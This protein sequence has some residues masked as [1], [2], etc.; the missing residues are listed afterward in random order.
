MA[1]VKNFGLIGV[2]TT[3]Q[4]GKGGPTLSANAAGGVLIADGIAGF[5]IPVG[6][7]LARPAG[8]DGIIRINSDLAAGSYTL[9]YFNGTAWSTVATGGSTGTIQ[10]EIDNIEASLGAGIDSTG[11]FLPGG[12]VAPIVGATSFTDAINQVALLADSADSLDE[13]FAPLATGNII[14]AVSDGDIGFD[15]AQGA[16][17]LTSGVQPY[18]QALTDFTANVTPGILVQTGPGAYASRTLVAPAEGITIT[19]EDGVA[20][21]PTLALANDLAGL[22]ALA[23]TG[24]SIRTGDGTWKTGTI[25]GT[26]GNIVVSNGDGVTTDTTI[27]LAPIVQASSGT[28]LKVEIGTFGRVIGNSAVVAADLTG[29]LDSTYVNVA[30]DTMADGANLTFVGGGTVTG[31]PDPVAPGD[32]SNKNY[33]DAR[34][35]GLTWK[36]PVAAATTIALPAATYDNG[37]TGVGATLTAV[38][39]LVVFPAID[40]IVSVVG[41]RILVKNQVVTTDNGIYTITALGDGAT[42]PW[43]LTRATDLDTAAEA[44]NATVFVTA[45]TTQ[46]GTGWTQITDIAVV[47]VEG[48]VFVQFTGSGTYAAGNGLTLTGNSFNVNMGA[49]IT[50]LPA[51]EVGIDLVSGLALQLT[52]ATTAGQLTFLLDGGNGVSGLEQSAT[53][54]K[55]PA[56]GVT[57]AM[58]ANPAIALNADNNAGTVAL[59]GEIE[60][61][62]DSIQGIS[63]SLE[64]DG[65]VF[66]ITAADATTASKG[67]SSFTATQFV[68]TDGNVAIGVI[69]ASSLPGEGLAIVISDGTATDDV[70][71]GETVVFTGDTIITTAVTDNEVTFTLGTVTPDHGGT[72]LE[73]IA[74]GGVLYGTALDTIGQ[75]AEFTFDG[76]LN[77]LTVGGGTISGGAVGDDFTI[78]AT[79]TDANINLLP[80]GAGAVVVGPAGAGAISSD[81]GATLTVTGATGLTLE[82]L[83]GA[84]D[85]TG[86]T[87]LLDSAGGITLTSGVGDIDF[88]L[89]GPGAVLH[90]NTPAAA[91][92]QASVTSN[93]DGNAIPNKLYVDA[94]IA[95]GG[96]ATASGAVKAVK[97]SVP[98]VDG[99]INIGA[100]LP[101]NSTVLSVKVNV[102]TPAT[103]GTLTVEGGANVYMSDVE[104]DITVGGIYLSETFFQE[105]GIT[106]VTATV[107]GAT[108]AGTAWVFVEYQNA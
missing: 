61:I 20:G 19:D 102:V 81:A 53:G 10:L 57:N 7:S 65:S 8:G 72:G 66:T 63:T 13:I 75:D 107:A 47:G 73:T 94:A 85:I 60:I 96:G 89:A 68:V 90:V 26:S 106:Q 91:T 45:G 88:N 14:Y 32:A 44:D 51:N 11:L 76:A 59:G 28:L 58:L 1:N 48:L 83:T 98:L 46:A 95:A 30:G 87:I 78:T 108:G 82:S 31:L 104:N 80:N 69:P 39:P 27:D 84:T 25:S 70:V 18:D 36:Q 55:I 92:Y 23:T 29:L 99:V 16:P 6:P 101:I 34:I 9:E 33:V 79:G 103:A 37:S 93:L 71:L 86:A 97:L 12:F 41:E 5:G 38:D 67:V 52:D 64:V 43:V 22:E 17:G 40:D 24:Y 56:L 77:L 21:N 74:A 54:L 35:A 100:A 62:G 2:G 15:W 42:I 3:V 105:P 4:Y 49:G 50:A